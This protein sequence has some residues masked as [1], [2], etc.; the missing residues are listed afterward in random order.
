MIFL[1]DFDKTITNKD[2][3]DELLREYNPKLLNETQIKF[4]VGEIN[5]KDYLSTLLGSL[6]FTIEKFEEEIIK[7]VE[8]DKDFSKFLSLVDDYRIVSAAT[9]NSIIAILKNSGIEIDESKIYSNGLSYDGEKLVVEYKHDYNDSFEGISKDILVEKYQ[10]E[11]GKVMFIGDGSSDLCICG[12][13][14][15]ILARK[16]Y[17]L[18]NYCIEN[19]YDYV[20]YENFGNIIEIVKKLATD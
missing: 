1:I 6:D 10:K 8:V 9:E 18:E 11:F 14:D 20:G 17:K 4:R 13:A 19:G 2:S 5:I 16:G 12:K 15:Y 3:T 7:R